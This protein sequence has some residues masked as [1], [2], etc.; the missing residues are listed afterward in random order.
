MKLSEVR[1]IATQLGLELG[2][3]KKSELIRSIQ[4]AEGNF[5]CY[6]TGMVRVC[7]QKCCLWR[8]D[9]R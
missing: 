1:E 9:C 6:N 8:T 7:G 4:T 2:R 5:A 3:M